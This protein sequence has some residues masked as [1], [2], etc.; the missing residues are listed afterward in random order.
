MASVEDLEYLKNLIKS[1]RIHIQIQDQMID[2]LNKNNEK[3]TK[4]LKD[5][6]ARYER[7]K[8]N[9]NVDDSNYD[10][11]SNNSTN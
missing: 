4:N 7:L 9:I 1:L 10:S 5:V 2:S 3:L 11:D 6:E 8:C